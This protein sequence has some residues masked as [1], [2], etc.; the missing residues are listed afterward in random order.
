MSEALAAMPEV[1]A[2]F[3]AFQY[4]VEVIQKSEQK[5]Q[6]GEHSSI[7]TGKNSSP[8]NE[9]PSVHSEN[10]QAD[11]PKRFNSSSRTNPPII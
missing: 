2:A 8:D 5:S 11:H 9:A 6:A 7:F 10:T 1:Q 3:C 4:E